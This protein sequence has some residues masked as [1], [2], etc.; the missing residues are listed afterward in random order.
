MKN[1]FYEQEGEFESINN[2]E[3]G[4]I[5][6]AIKAMTAAFFVLVSGICCLTVKDMSFLPADIAKKFFN[7]D[8]SK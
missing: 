4:C 2:G 1:S 5:E 6:S 8:W 7:E 3:N